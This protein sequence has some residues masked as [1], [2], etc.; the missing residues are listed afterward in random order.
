MKSKKEFDWTLNNLIKINNKY[1]KAELKGKTED[2]FKIAEAIAKA[3]EEI[4]IGEEK[5]KKEVE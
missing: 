5:E 3:C 1:V 4:K 2:I